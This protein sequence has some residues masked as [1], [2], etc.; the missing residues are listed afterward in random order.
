MPQAKLGG[1]PLAEAL[2]KAES[3]ADRYIVSMIH[4]E[5][6]YRIMT[7]FLEYMNDPR[8]L[9]LKVEEL[10]TQTDDRYYQQI[11]DFL[12]LGDKPQFVEAL[13]QASPA[14]KQEL[15]KH[16]TGAFRAKQPYAQFE[17]KAKEYFDEHL[18]PYATQLGYSY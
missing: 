17:T 8:F 3:E 13:K 2:A 6:L 12:R 16:S 5:P 7:S 10:F 18:V 9:R 4:F 14:F 11:A 15:P 1:I